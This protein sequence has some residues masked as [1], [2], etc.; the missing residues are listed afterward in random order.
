VNKQGGAQIK[1]EEQRKKG[2]K[3]GL[4]K[5]HIGSVGTKRW[6]AKDRG[7]QKTPLY[8]RE[9]TKNRPIWSK[10]SVKGGK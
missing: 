9:K 7:F 4:T 2:E 8:S 5:I 10:R 3:R 1:K 6:T